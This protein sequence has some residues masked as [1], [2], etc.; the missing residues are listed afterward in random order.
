MLLLCSLTFAIGQTTAVLKK[1]IKDE[2]YATNCQ[3]E[4]NSL[5][6]LLIT[7]FLTKANNKKEKIHNEIQ[8]FFADYKLNN[9]NLSHYNYPTTLDK[10]NL[11]ITVTGYDNNWGLLPKSG[12]TSLLEGYG[13]H[14]L[15]AIITIP[16]FDNYHRGYSLN[17]ITFFCTLTEN[18][19]WTQ[20]RNTDSPIEKLPSYKREIEIEIKLLD[21]DK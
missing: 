2:A 16:I 7:K 6:T 3:N 20:T 1:V 11:T 19:Y 9:N 4:I 8:D 21:L 10:T 13:N 15:N 17:S 5:K 18:I 12:D 14:N